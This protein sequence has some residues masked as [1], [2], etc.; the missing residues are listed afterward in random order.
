MESVTVQG[1]T[2]S[3]RRRAPRPAPMESRPPTTF[4]INGAFANLQISANVINLEQKSSC[5]TMANDV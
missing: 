2:I 4:G 3:D 5:R 1:N